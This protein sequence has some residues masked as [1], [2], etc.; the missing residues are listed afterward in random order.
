M[1]CHI[2]YH[3]DHGMMQNLRI[4]AEVP[5]AVDARPLNSIAGLPG[6]FGELLLGGRHGIHQQLVRSQ[7][8]FVIVDLRGNDQF[9]GAG[10]LDESSTCLLTLAGVPI[11]LQARKF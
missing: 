10:A 2:M 3:G 1:H 9:V 7:P 8:R 6:S 5:D 11:A 4:A